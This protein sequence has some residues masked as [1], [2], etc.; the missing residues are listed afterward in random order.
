MADDPDTIRL[1]EMI[2]RNTQYLTGKSP[3]Q[4]FNSGAGSKGIASKASEAFDSTLNRLTGS[5]RL[6]HGSADDVVSSFTRML[7]YGALG[8]AVTALIENLRSTSRTYSQMTAVG[9]NFGGSM[10]K[11]QEIAG[12]S[13]LSL[14][15]FA[16]EVTHNSILIS[17][18]GDSQLA[19]VA[20]FGKFQKGVRDNLSGM[21]MYGMTLNEVNTASGDFAESLRESGQWSRMT[22]KQ[23]TDAAG[24]MIKDVNELSQATGKSRDEIMKLL[25]GAIRDPMT[26]GRLGTMGADQNEIYR[27]MVVTFAGAAGDAAPYLTKFFSETLAGGNAQWS[28]AG[29]SLISVGLGN[30]AGLMNNMV[31]RV[32]QGGERTAADE[33]NQISTELE[34]RDRILER[35]NTLQN[36]A[37]AG[38]AG[39]KQAL[40][41]ANALRG[42]TKEGMIKRLED[43]RKSGMEGI[44]KAMTMLPNFL[45]DTL[46]KFRQGFYHSFLGIPEGSDGLRR[47]EQFESSLNKIR[48]TLV[49]F[50]AR[51]G[52]MAQKLL[53]SFVDNLPAIGEDL[54]KFLN[55]VEVLGPK[56]ETGLSG[57]ATAVEWV[58][59]RIQA[60][61]KF[62]GIGG[63][64][65]QEGDESR[66]AIA[67]AGVVAGLVFFRT[68]L[69]LLTGTLTLFKTAVIKA[70]G[71][72]DAGPGPRLDDLHGGGSKPGRKPMGAVGQ[73][74]TIVGSI[75]A[76]EF[77]KDKTLNMLPESVSQNETVKT[78]ADIAA[79]LMATMIGS[80]LMPA[81]LELLSVGFA[82]I[83]AAVPLAIIAAGVALTYGIHALGNKLDPDAKFGT[84]RDEHIWGASFIDNALSK[85]GLGRGYEEQSKDAAALHEKEAAEALQKATE[86]IN[87]QADRNKPP[88]GTPPAAT[89]PAEEP[90]VVAPKK[91]APGGRGGSVHQQ[92]PPDHA[93]SSL[94][95]QVAQEKA[96]L[97]AD[98]EEADRYRALRDD[99]LPVGA[100]VNRKTGEV[101]IS[102]M[103]MAEEAHRLA[104]LEAAGPTTPTMPVEDP[105]PV[106]AAGLTPS[107]DVGEVYFGD[108]AH[109]DE[110][111]RIS[112]FEHQRRQKKEADEI[113]AR[114][115]VR[116]A[117]PDLAKNDDTVWDHL[118]TGQTPTPAQ[119]SLEDKLGALVELQIQANQIAADAAKN[120]KPE[121]FK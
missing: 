70:I 97:D 3:T 113:R 77:L 72:L 7:G 109:H 4:S 74:A 42:E 121:P 93:M 44:T 73:T 80:A 76:G 50:G 62:L 56:L 65:D 107:A 87:K 105:T 89:A 116:A 84:W 82:S 1:L 119:Q 18:M 68:T 86:E 120:A 14:E 40:A 60:A 15:D 92:L 114:N 41:F 63:G 104:A 23:R 67:T 100:S 91:H 27:K 83:A 90:G 106:V 30:V 61:L 17:Q 112:K 36:L 38:D 51:L 25:N 33:A 32:K 111:K 54:N 49:P 2:G 12:A 71:G 103:K 98:A 28:E 8:G 39:A 55:T 117:N 53:N 37:N 16:K 34:M 20:A 66:K 79:P 69:K 46:G 95:R 57:L 102:H 6:M 99:Q 94:D 24:V 9:V 48:D 78:I 110:G 85:I 35:Y 13:G 52:E 47:A 26:A 29:K 10:F 101:S 22:D 64:D 21:G 115:Q 31:D 11:M 43:A 118:S 75:I 5:L 88:G 81:I 45:S 96:K 108:A 59:D 58:R 19:G